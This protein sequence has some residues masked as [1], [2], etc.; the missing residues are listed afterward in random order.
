MTEA[1]D[2][3][4]EWRR[5][6]G[7]AAYEISSAGRVRR[8]KSKQRKTLFVSLATHL[9]PGGYPSMHFFMDGR[10]VTRQIHPLVCEAFH[11]VK[12][13]PDHEAAHWDGIKTNNSASN[14]RWATPAENSA[15]RDRHG[16]RARGVKL[17]TAKLTDEKV[18]EIR[19]LVDQGYG[20][21]AIATNFA[22]SP[23][24]ISRVKLRHSWRHI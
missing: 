2:M 23:A 6:P 10:G 7:F 12:P 20:T 4:E 18:R 11:G 14:L 21:L 1:E 8:V 19:A 3:V 13:T 5:C 9:N 22:V 24:T 17:R 15:D 16:T